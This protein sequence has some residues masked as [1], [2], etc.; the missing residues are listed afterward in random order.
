MGLRGHFQGELRRCFIYVEVQHDGLIRRP[1][2]SSY[3]VSHTRL[4]TLLQAYLRT[5]IPFSVG[6]TDLKCQNP[7]HESCP[8]GSDI[9][10]HRRLCT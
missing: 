9:Y 4:N 1:W 6:E 10:L 5:R 8:M 7:F 3:L 2:S